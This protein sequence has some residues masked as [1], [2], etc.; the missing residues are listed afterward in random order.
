MERGSGLFRFYMGIGMHSYEEALAMVLETVR[1]VGVERVAL[2]EAAGR[3]LAA[4]IRADRDLPPFDRSERDG[5]AVRSADFADGRA[6]LAWD[7]RAVFAGDDPG[8][9]VR[10]GACV[11]IM[12]GAALPPGADAVVMVERSAVK[13]G[14]VT[15]EE[16]R[17]SPGL[18]VHPRGADAPAGEDLVPAG[19]PLTPARIAVAASVGAAEPEVRRRVRVSVISTGDELTS[20]AGDPGPNRIRECNGPALG[21][22][23]GASPWMEL[24]SWRM[25]ADDGA[26][27]EEAIRK[28][29]ALSDAVVLSGG[30]SMGEKDLVP[31]ALAASGVE[32]VL[33]GVAI[34]PGKPFWFGAAAGH[35]VVFGLPGNP[36]SLQVT[37]RE[38]AL[39]GIRKMAGWREPRS[40]AIRIPAAAAVDKTFPLRQFLPAR[41]EAGEGGRTEARPLEHRGSGDFVS[42]SR[43]E[44]VIVL[45][46]GPV[47]VPPG[48]LVTFHP[49]SLS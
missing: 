35:P 19:L 28:G 22:I 13:K 36:V 20:F 45:P 38:F 40:P 9:P 11:K 44:G 27:L 46:E 14:V 2:T 49:W 5:W 10:G 8:A 17:I 47:R 23:I 16:G 41:L 43:A 33:H 26:A 37:F 42:A 4:P 6:R 30:V 32:R 1:P 15:M 48:D 34:R 18:H 24:R 25:V 7:G 3:V 12:T 29:L 21:A 31:D 39:P